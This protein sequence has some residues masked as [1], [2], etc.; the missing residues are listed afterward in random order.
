MSPGISP[1]WPGPGKLSE[2]QCQAGTGGTGS[3]AWLSARGGAAHATI[4]ADDGNLRVRFLPSLS[5]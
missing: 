1:R 2:K 3:L 4:A 5:D